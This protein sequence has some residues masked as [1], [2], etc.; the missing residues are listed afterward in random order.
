M[1]LLPSSGITRI[2]DEFDEEDEEGWKEGPSVTLREILLQAGGD[3]L[4][5]MPCVGNETFGWE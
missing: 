5:G 3:D 2:S 1:E 4:L